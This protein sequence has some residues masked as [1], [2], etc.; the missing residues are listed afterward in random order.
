MAGITDP[1]VSSSR[2]CCPCQGRQSPCSTNIAT[3]HDIS[4]CSA[5]AETSSR[6]MKRGSLTPQELTLHHSLS[7]TGIPGGFFCACSRPAMTRK[8][9][10]ALRRT[11]PSRSAR[12][13]VR[14]TSRT[15]A[16]C[17]HSAAWCST[18]PPCSCCRC[19]RRWCC[20]SDV[21]PPLSSAAIWSPIPN[22]KE[23][24]REEAFYRRTDHRLPA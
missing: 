18:C 5:R 14:L 21:P 22:D 9:P 15:A 4:P 20:R 13:P 19:S 24:G 3:V 2:H 11:G 17:A 8:S 6:H 10:P 7:T 16:G 1:A 23:I 12:K